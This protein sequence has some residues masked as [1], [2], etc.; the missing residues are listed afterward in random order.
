MLRDLGVDLAQVRAEVEKLAKS[1]QAVT[2]GAL[3][4]AR[5]A[6]RVTMLAGAESRR[7]GHSYV[8]TEHLLLGLLREEDG[9]AAQVLIRLGVKLEAVRAEVVKL[10]ARDSEP[11]ASFEQ[12]TS[13]PP[14]KRRVDEFARV[15]PLGRLLSDAVMELASRKEKAA[16]RGQHELAGQMFE[17]A[18]MIRGILQRL[19]GA[20]GRDEGQGPSGA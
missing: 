10:S 11:A 19:A 20:A 12:V 18:E 3:P 14:E 17:M 9:A 2:S 16:W 6:M 7:L 4:L 1:G 8:G 5:R 15:D 13:E